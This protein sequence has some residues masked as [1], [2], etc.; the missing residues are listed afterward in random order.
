MS[1]KENAKRWRQSAKGK[2]S[3]RLSNWKYRNRPD[4]KEKARTYHREYQHKFRATDK[5]KEYRRK[6]NQLPQTKEAKRRYKYSE[7]GILSRYKYKARKRGLVWDLLDCQ[8]KY[9]FNQNCFYCGKSPVPG[10]LIGIDRVDNDRGYTVDNVHPCC[11]PCNW[12]KGKQTLDEF[13]ESC[14]DRYK[15]LFLS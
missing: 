11:G 7:A 6:M 13:L 12:A 14:L 10:K 5:G 2:A 9:I 3:R 15:T 1:T 4:V 8:A